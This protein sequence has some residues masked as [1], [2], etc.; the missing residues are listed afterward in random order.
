MSSYSRSLLLL[1]ILVVFGFHATYASAAS[2]NPWD[3]NWSH[4]DQTATQAPSP[5][6]R[7]LF[8]PA[9]GETAAPS[10]LVS[11]GGLAVALEADAVGAPPAA[12]QQTGQEPVN[13]R[14]RSFEYSR[15]YNLRR[16][17]H[18]YASVATLPLFATE[19]YL[20]Q[21]LYNGGFTDGQRTAHQW[22]AGGIGALFG[23][24]TVTGLWNLKEG[25]KDPSH[26]GLRVAHG[27]LMLGADAGFVAT[28]ALAPNREG[29]GG[30]RGAHRA[31]AFTSIGV[32]TAGYLI[33][34]LGR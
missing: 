22:V 18:V 15:A 3:V 9:T 12:G 27:L 6:W 21:K 33:M 19:V 1:L 17:I 13:A 32:A 28:G 16:R 34:L 24:N 2:R 31:I 14:P 8:S 4:P 7:V 26:H 10:S 29:E 23:V 25:W 5:A 20:G 11:T 30:S